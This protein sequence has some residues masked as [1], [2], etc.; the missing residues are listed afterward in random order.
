MLNI[1]I[2]ASDITRYLLLK[3][4]SSN[5]VCKFNCNICNDIYNGKTKRHFI[6]RACEHLGITPLTGKKMKSPKKCSI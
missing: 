6:V 5:L 3:I 2:Y 1:Y 4:K